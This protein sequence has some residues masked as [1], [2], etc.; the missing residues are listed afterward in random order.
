LES[1]PQNST[2]RVS[3]EIIV[4]III[5]KNPSIYNARAM[6]SVKVFPE[7]MGGRSIILIE[8]HRLYA[9]LTG[10]RTRKEPELD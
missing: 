9:C 3:R 4:I 1:H 5:Q 8:L 10:Q 2:L 6:P 7:I